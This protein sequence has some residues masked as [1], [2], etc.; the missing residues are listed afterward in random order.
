MKMPANCPICNSLMAGNERIDYSFPLPSNNLL[1]ISCDKKI[2]H[3]L[4]FGSLVNNYN[5]VG[6]IVVKLLRSNRSEAIWRPEKKKL[7]IIAYSPYSEF[8]L[9]YFEPDFSDYNKLIEKL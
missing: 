6:F 3:C 5:V 1:Q 8:Y 4:I 7:C 2:D 9:P